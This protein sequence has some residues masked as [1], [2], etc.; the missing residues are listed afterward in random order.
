MDKVPPADKLN[1][2]VCRCLLAYVNGFLRLEVHH[3][4]AILVSN[5]KI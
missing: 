1:V 5:V 2:T 3:S 4:P